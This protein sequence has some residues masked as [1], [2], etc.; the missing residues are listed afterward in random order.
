MVP[1]TTVRTAT[2]VQI[3]EEGVGEIKKMND[4]LPGRWSAADGGQGID[5][6]SSGLRV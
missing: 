3:T 1:V 2:D 6:R 4:N 5:V